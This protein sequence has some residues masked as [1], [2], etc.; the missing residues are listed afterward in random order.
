MKPFTIDFAGRQSPWRWDLR[1]PGTRLFVVLA[2]ASLLALVAAWRQAAAIEDERREVDATL[3]RLVTQQEAQDESQRTRARATG[4]QAALLHQAALRRALPWEAIF[5]AFEDAP[6]ARLA[7]LQPD[8]ARG[9]VRA[10]AHLDDVGEV[11]GYLDTLATSPVLA[12]VTLQRHEVPAQGGGVDFSYEALLAAP[13]R[14]P[15]QDAGG[16]P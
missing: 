5:R 4:E 1:M 7:A 3:A 8:V 13:Y 15:D 12:R 14:L 6:T 2:L 10:Q 16:K 9:V 11:Q